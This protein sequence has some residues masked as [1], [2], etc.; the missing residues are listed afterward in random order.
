MT[1]PPTEVKPTDSGQTMSASVASAATVA[2]RV[3]ASKAVEM[4]V[5]GGKNMRIGLGSGSTVVHVASALKQ[6]G[7]C[8]SIETFSIDFI[9]DKS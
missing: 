6:V 9:H 5:N 7:N 1:S 8:D 3:A 4:F 2:K